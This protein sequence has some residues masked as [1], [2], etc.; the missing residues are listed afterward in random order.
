MWRNREVDGFI[1]WLR[2][3]NAALDPEARVGF[4]GLDLYNLG[5]SIRAVI[6]YLDDRDP[7][8]ARVARER[9]GC[10]QPWSRNP[11][12]YGRMAIT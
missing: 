5:A 8:A 10:L 4:Y 1:R 6:D 7:A 11:A 12:A 3:H 2:R 9:Y